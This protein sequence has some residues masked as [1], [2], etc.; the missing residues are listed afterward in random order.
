M[1]ISP[2]LNLVFFISVT[3]EYRLRYRVGK[4]IFFR[5]SCGHWKRPKHRRSVQN[6]ALERKEINKSEIGFYNVHHGFRPNL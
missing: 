3:S 5:T 1:N 6:L 4:I 2:S